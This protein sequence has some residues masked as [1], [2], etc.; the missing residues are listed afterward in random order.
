MDKKT[1]INKDKQYVY[2]GQYYH[3]KNKELPFDFKFGVTKNLTQREY[4]LGNTKSPI[5][6]MILRAWELPKM[7]TREEVEH[8]I[9]LVFDENKYDGC[10]WYD[11]DVETFEGKISEIFKCLTKMYN[12]SEYIFKEVDL[13]FVSDTDDI[14][15]KEIE[16]EV[17][18]GKKAAWTNLNIT[19]EGESIEGDKAKNKFVNCVKK[20]L[21]Y[22]EPIQLLI[23]FG[24]IFKKDKES[25]ATYKQKQL[26][27]VGNHY[28]TT[29]SSTLSKKKY[30]LKMFEKYN[31]NGEVNII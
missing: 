10:E 23:D 5:K 15:E 9:A 29:H 6:Y 12:I 11:I 20:I 13:D 16:S 14:V 2:I 28:L 30:I 31:I 21:E 7:V 27:I 17:R 1:T 3:I 25:F 4:S 24:D 8:L 26:T 19:I 22:V 18:K